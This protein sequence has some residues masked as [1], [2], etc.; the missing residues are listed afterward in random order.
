[1]NRA[2]KEIFLR[3]YEELCDLVEEKEN[4]I[5]AF[6]SKIENAKVQKISGMPFGGKTSGLE[7][8]MA[9]LEVLEKEW[10]KAESTRLGRYEDIVE[11]IAKLADE[12]ER[13]VLCMRYLEFHPWNTIAHSIGRKLRQTHNIY[14]RAVRNLEL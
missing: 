12:T 11:A 6:Q 5:E 14:A 7:D 1:M 3:G 9:K 10:F 8:A 13:T 2:E 4:D